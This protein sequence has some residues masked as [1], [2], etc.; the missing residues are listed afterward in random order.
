MET[1][2][3]NLRY[4]GYRC[5]IQGLNFYQYILTYWDNLYDY[6]RSDKDKLVMLE[7]IPDF[8]QD[9]D[10]KNKDNISDG[11]K[12]HNIEYVKF[13]YESEPY[14]L[15]VSDNEG[16]NLIHGNLDKLKENHNY[17]LDVEFILY[18]EC[19][20]IIE[21]A[22]ISRF[23]RKCMI[24][25]TYLPWIKSKYSF[26]ADTLFENGVIYNSTY[27]RIVENVDKYRFVIK[28]VSRDA[29]INEYDNVIFYINDDNQV[30]V[31]PQ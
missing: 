20:K 22:N 9:L 12:N 16:I 24:Q 29:F 19:D 1:V 13:L 5:V 4:Y 8:I 2:N 15:F 7:Y 14:N 10:L 25:N 6:Y 27:Q 18:D 28:I 17:F 23:I 21:I 30:V 3:T 31:Y 11:R 26:W